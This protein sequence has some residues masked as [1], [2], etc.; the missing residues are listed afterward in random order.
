VRLE[1]NILHI[2]EVQFARKTAVRQNVLYINQQELKK[3][4]KEDKRLREVD[5]ELANPGEKCR[6]LR[7][8]DVIEPRAK[9]V[10]SGQDFP[11][12]LGKQ[13]TAGQGRTY[14]LRDSAV[15]VSEYIE[16]GQLA[17][18]NLARDI[19]DMWGP[20]AEISPY[21]KTC[22]VVLLPY[23]AN[24]TSL[25]EYRVALKIAGLKTA[26]YLA[27][28]RADLK[29]EGVEV[30]DLPPPTEIARYF[31]DIPKVTYIFQ[32]LTNQYEPVAGE[33]IL[34]G[35]NIEKI[36]PTI[37]HPNEV[38]DGAITTPHG[39]FFVETYVIQ[40]HPIIKELYQNHG[41]SLCFTGVI[42]T[43]APNNVPEYERTANIAAN[44][45][46]H[47][48]GVDGVILSKTGGGAP[49]LVMARTAQRCEELGIKTALA[50]LH[51]GIDTTDT[52]LKA[53]TIFNMPEVDAMVSMGAP[54]GTITL[55]PAE[56]IIGIPAIMPEGLQV[57]R[58]IERPI[59][60]IRG[61]MSQLGNSMLTAVR[62]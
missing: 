43:N 8:A 19:I 21:G 22:N 37:L 62:Y 52:S 20:A 58:E 33:P 49:E 25:E 14:V 28:A 2:R 30:Y 54:T 47:V 26:A 1:L 27:K 34:Y 32:V 51:M 29:P 40:N 7:V 18:P 41:K 53:S 35:D 23:P 39:S 9:D 4:L 16:P 6:I 42:I 55:P 45:A 11:G 15:V 50:L 12:A 36:V 38:L 5:I 24:G 59:I 61:S 13:G 60:H 48:L 10:K 46:K 31:P 17:D 3:L 44:L 57:S 56:R